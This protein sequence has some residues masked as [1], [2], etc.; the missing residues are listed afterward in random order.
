MEK[1]GKLIQRQIINYSKL[2][3]DRNIYNILFKLF[4]FI[5]LKTNQFFPI[6]ELK[7]TRMDN[8]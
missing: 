7:A 4:Y 2:L 6:S 8:R 1:N 5:I 3:I